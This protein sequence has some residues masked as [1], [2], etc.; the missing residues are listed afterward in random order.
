MWL[1]PFVCLTCVNPSEEFLAPLCAWSATFYRTGCTPDYSLVLFFPSFS[2]CNEGGNA[3]APTRPCWHVLKGKLIKRFTRSY[4]PG[5]WRKHSS[6]FWAESIYLAHMLW[7]TEIVS[8]VGNETCFLLFLLQPV[9]T[10]FYCLSYWQ[11]P[12]WSPI[13]AFLALITGRMFAVGEWTVSL[14]A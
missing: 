13:P 6:V 8:D 3:T 5:I 11:L 2:A 4:P 1:L 7:T 10:E 12:P 14:F 9:F